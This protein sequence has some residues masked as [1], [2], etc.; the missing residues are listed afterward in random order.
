MIHAVRRGTIYY[1]WVIAGAAFVIMYAAYGV[2]Y[3]FGVFLPEMEAALSP[4]R[5]AAISLGFSIYSVVYSGFSLVSGRLT[6]L[7]GPRL[8]V[9][10]GGGLLGAG[11]VLTSRSSELWQFYVWYGLL[12]G[13]GMSAVFV[14]TTATTVK[15][16]VARRGLVLGLVTMGAGLG[17]LT[18]PLLSAAL[19]AA[20]GWRTTF[21]VYGLALA[22]ILLVAGMRLERD[23]ESLGLRPYG[24]GDRHQGD[25]SAGPPEAS[26]GPAAAV[27]TTAFWLYT[28]ALFV[29]WS[30]VFLPVVHLPSFAQSSLGASSGQAA[31][32]VAAL[33]A[34]STFGRFAAGSVSDRL[35][36][37]RTF[38]VSVWIQVL[39][40]LGLVLASRIESLP[41]TYAAALA[42]GTSLGSTTALHPI[43]VGDLFGRHFAASVSGL[44]FAAASTSTAIGVYVG[45]ALQ[46]ATGSYLSSFVLGAA[47]TVLALPP[48]LLMRSPQPQR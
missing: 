25:G 3:S 6:D 27:R 48:I 30:V 24:L 37:R 28:V 2:Q 47:L 33:A 21:T 43:V 13:L 12:A 10:A 32:T 18:V 36:S 40:F 46:E 14:P 41:M 26:F 4:G 20:L 39:G 11:L 35:G 23:P 17:Q 1:G 16:F 34:G 42:V 15:W 38:V 29:F 44:I 9:L 7:H 19:I 5:R 8:V 22:L 45:G 31:L